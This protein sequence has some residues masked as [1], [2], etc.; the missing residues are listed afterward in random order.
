[1]ILSVGLVEGRRTIRVELLA[2][3]V[4][5]AGRVFPS[6]RHEIGGP[7]SLRPEDPA[8]GAFA[9]LDVTIGIGF[10]WQREERQVFRGAL[11]VVEDRGLTAINDVPLDEYVTSVI[12]SEMSAS[13]PLELLKAHAVISRSWLV[14]PRS[15]P[16]VAGR[17]NAELLRP[18][19]VIRWYGRE[20]HR[21]FDVCADDHCQRYQGIT[22]AFSPAAARAVAE[23]AGELLL[24][25]DRICDAR[26]SKCCGGVSERF[27]SAWDDREV[28]YL[29]PVYDGPPPAPAFEAAAWIL[30]DPPAYCNTEDQALLALLLPGFDQETRDF[31]RWTAVLTGEEIRRHVS[32]KLGVDLGVVRALEPLERGASGRIVRLRLT[33]DA[34]ALVVGKEL[35]IRRA[36]APTHLLSSAFVVDEVA[37]RFT[38]HGA[39]WGHGVGLCQIGAAVMASQGHDYRQILAHYY[40][41]TTL[42]PAP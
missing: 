27:R 31:F 17:G 9:V 37:G 36:L 24:H 40:P 13:C 1:V 11:R 3:F 18:G 39:G 21:L 29:S 35:E 12:S 25:R 28:P 4:D 20:A 42:G 2:P 5:A 6:G 30:G 38:L 10:H 41:G 8:S 22:K 23:T 7:L 32:E 16:E 33:G 26:F 19:E 34:G 14:H 15:Q